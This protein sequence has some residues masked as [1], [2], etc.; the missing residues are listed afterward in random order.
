MTKTD[1]RAVSRASAFGGGRRLT[2][3]RWGHIGRH[4][5]LRVNGH[6]PA[7]GS[8]LSNSGHLPVLQPL[9]R[10]LL[11][12]ALVL[13]FAPA[14]WADGELDKSFGTNG[15]AILAL[16]VQDISTIGGTTEAV[17][18]G[19]SVSVVRLSPA[20]TIMGSPQI[21]P[22]NVIT[23]L[24]AL[25]RDSVTGDIWAAG[26]RAKRFCL[27]PSP[28]GCRGTAYTYTA[29][30]ARFSATGALIASYEGGNCVGTKIL[31][32]QNGPIAV[33]VSQ[34]YLRAFQVVRLN[35]EGNQLAVTVSAAF[36]DRGAGAL[37]RDGSSGAYYIGGYACSVVQCKAAQY[38]MRLDA[39]SLVPD[40]SYGA[41][42]VA[43]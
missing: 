25:V 37:L 36:S 26:Y 30:F 32:D 40:P 16:P 28:T 23:R 12:L 1:Y 38:V 9:M 6:D 18:M 13:S 17:G 39:G 31:V 2:T 34:H 11:Q 21:S 7:N 3:E 27:F 42:G 10:M 29:Q 35:T 8:S 20:G 19:E 33:C 5:W 15:V 43:Q 24:T 22:Q 41:S 14:A 4:E